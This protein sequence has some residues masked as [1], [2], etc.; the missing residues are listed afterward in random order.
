MEGRYGLLIL[1]EGGFLRKGSKLW[2]IRMQASQLVTET[3]AF[4][5]RVEICGITWW[6]LETCHF[7][8]ISCSMI[9]IVVDLVDLNPGVLHNVAFELRSHLAVTPVSTSSCYQQ[10]TGGLK[11]WIHLP[12]MH[13]VLFWMIISVATNSRPNIFEY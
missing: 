13:T 10:R 9:V 2:L 12:A 6:K 7:Q 5:K 11:L 1:E 3:L 4:W 8:R